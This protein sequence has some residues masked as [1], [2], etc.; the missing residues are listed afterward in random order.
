VL[1]TDREFRFSRRQALSPGEK[2]VPSNISASWTPLQFET[3]IGGVLQGRR[4]HDLKAASCVCKRRMWK[5]ALE[6]A[7]LVAVPRIERGLRGGMYGDVKGDELLRYRRSVKES[8]RT[9]PLQ[10]WVRNVGGEEF[11]IEGVGI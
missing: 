6:I 9:G 4:Q 7:A 11:G 10:G 1:T 3:L 2:L 5:L 8:V